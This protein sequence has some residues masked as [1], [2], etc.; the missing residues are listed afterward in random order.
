MFGP[1]DQLARS[2]EDVSARAS[3]GIMLV[4]ALA[5]SP[6]HHTCLPASQSVSHR[7]RRLNARIHEVEETRGSGIRP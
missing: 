3:K 5:S 7:E 4:D 1:P 6:L 2:G